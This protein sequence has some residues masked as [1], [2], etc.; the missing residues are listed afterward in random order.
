VFCLEQSV[1]VVMGWHYISLGDK[2]FRLLRLLKVAR[3]GT[4]SLS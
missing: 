4:P 2:Q 3:P 1:G